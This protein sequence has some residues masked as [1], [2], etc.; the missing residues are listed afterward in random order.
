MCIR[1][2]IVRKQIAEITKGVAHQK[3]S[4]DRF[5]TIALPVAPL[6]EQ[7]EIAKRIKTAFSRVDRLAAEATNSRKLIDHLD[8][9]ILA[10]AFRGELAPQDPSDEPASVLLDRIKASKQASNG[11][12]RKAGRDLFFG[13]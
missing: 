4:L 5:R 7:E 3:V 12:K 10:K 8:Q 9:G 13:D 1:C 11:R 6:E 2:E